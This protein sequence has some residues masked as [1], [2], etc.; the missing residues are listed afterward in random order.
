MI[1]DRVKFVQ[2]F[3]KSRYTKLNRQIRELK[4]T[5]YCLSH[6]HNENPKSMEIVEQT[7]IQDQTIQLVEEV[8][9]S[10]FD[11]FKNKYG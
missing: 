8:L 6:K 1:I 2:E 5:D 3:V 9:K 7:V 4:K 10:Q 11:S